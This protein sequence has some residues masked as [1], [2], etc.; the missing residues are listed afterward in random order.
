MG[1]ALRYEVYTTNTPYGKEFPGDL[2]RHHT[3]NVVVPGFRGIACL[4]PDFVSVSCIRPPVTYS[5][6][7]SVLEDDGPE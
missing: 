3:D 5:R 4:I 7:T 1:S 2:G 6:I